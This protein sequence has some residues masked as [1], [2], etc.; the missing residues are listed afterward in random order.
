MAT[1]A[2]AD[3]NHEGHRGYVIDQIRDE[4]MVGIYAAANIV[5]LHAGTNDMKNNVDPI[6]A[7]ARLKDLIDI[8]F[9]HSSNAVVFVC[10]IIPASSSNYPDTVPRIGTFN[11]AIP[12]LVSDYVSAGKKVMMVSMNQAVSTSDLADGLH[13]NDG[14]YAKMA[15]TYYAAIGDA[16]E[17]GWISKPG[18]SQTA[19]S[20]TGPVNC[21]STPSWYRVGQIAT[22]AKVYVSRSLSQTIVLFSLSRETNTDESFLS[23]LL[24]MVHSSPHGSNGVSSPKGLALVPSF[25]SWISTAMA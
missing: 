2:M 19:P 18:N 25:I 10:Q 5:L 16:D 13:P 14:G 8:I 24:L 15:D 1:G 17:K 9:A 4:S 21:K 22:G 12:K 7:P 6:N 11:N 3:N 23:A 20:P